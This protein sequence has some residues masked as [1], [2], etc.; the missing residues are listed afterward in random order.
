MRDFATDFDHTDPIFNDQMTTITADL[1][2]RCPLAHGEAHGGLWALSRYQDIMEVLH[3]HKTFSS[4]KDT[5]IPIID[6]RMKAL[7]LTT[8]PPEHTRYR[9]FFTSWLMVQRINQHE[10]LIRNLMND[11][12]NAFIQDG[13][14][15]LVPTLTTSFPSSVTALILGLA[16]K[17]WPLLT[18]Y[19]QRILTTAVASDDEGNLKARQALIHYILKELEKRRIKPRN[20]L[21]SSLATPQSNGESLTSEEIINLMAT[22]L[23]ASYK[24]VAD[25]L[26]ILLLYLAEHPDE[27]QRLIDNPALITLAVEESFRYYSPFQFVGRHVAHQCVLHQQEINAG[28]KILLMLGSA[29][30]D[31]TQFS[32]A[33]DFILDRQP[34]RHIAFGYGIHTCPGAHL[35]RVELRVAVEEFLRRI[36]D[37]RLAHSFENKFPPGQPHEVLTLPVTFSP[38]ERE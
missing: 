34:N 32:E 8:D 14:C 2:K 35:A 9:R 22:M 25:A 24:P 31:E 1:R 6:D 33:D 38:G 11:H 27:R 26:G 7:P 5:T 28:E 18:H 4:E 10:P 37:Y 16:P 13:A 30:H 15:D 3:N 19:M 17:D 20:D 23:T 36:P 29:N 21:L 12:I